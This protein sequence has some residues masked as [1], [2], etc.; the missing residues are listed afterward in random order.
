MADKSGIVK[1]NTK[2]YGYSYTSLSDIVRQEYKLP[3]MKTGTDPA[4]GKDYIYY[5]DDEIKDWIRGAE[6]IIPQMKGMNA[7]QMYGAAIS[8]ARRYTAMMC[9]SLASSDDEKLE[10]KEPEQQ[11]P[12]NKSGIWDEPIQQEKPKENLKSLKILADEFRKVVP[13]EAQT[14][15]LADFQTTKAEDLGTINLQKYVNHY[16]QIKPNQ[17]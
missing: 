3:K 8:F 6:I 15:I 12:S 11:K 16:G 4:N 7:S 5:F 9:L 10:S 13:Q 14:K 17:S 2:A 1:A